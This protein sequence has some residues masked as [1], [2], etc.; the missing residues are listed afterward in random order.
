MSY[1]LSDIILKVL[2][3]LKTSSDG[4]SRPGSASNL[5]K[6]GYP[7]QTQEIEFLRSRLFSKESKH[8]RLASVGLLMLSS[9]DFGPQNHKMTE[10]VG[11]HFW[12]SLTK[13]L[14]TEDL[15]SVVHTILAGAKVARQRSEYQETKNSIKR[16]DSGSSST[17]DLSQSKRSQGARE[18]SGHSQEDQNDVNKAQDLL[19]VGKFKIYYCKKNKIFGTKKSQNGQYLSASEQARQVDV[20]ANRTKHLTLQDLEERFQKGGFLPD[21]VKYVLWVDHASGSPESIK[22]G[23]G[24]AKEGFSKSFK[25]QKGSRK[26]QA[27]FEDRMFQRGLKGHEEENL[28]LC[29]SQ[30]PFKKLRSHVNEHRTQKSIISSK[31][32]WKSFKIRKRKN[33]IKEV[34]GAPRGPFNHLG[35]QTEAFKRDI[36]GKSRKR[37]LNSEDSVGSKRSII[38][39]SGGE[40]GVK[41][42]LGRSI[43]DE[44]TSN[45]GGIQKSGKRRFRTRGSLSRKLRGQ[46]GSIMRASR[47]NQHETTIGNHQ[48]DQKSQKSNNPKFTTKTS[49]EYNMNPTTITKE[50][51]QSTGR[52]LHPESKKS[53]LESIQKYQGVQR[54]TSHHLGVRGLRARSQQANNRN[55]VKSENQ[56]VEENQDFRKKRTRNFVVK[57]RASS[58]GKPPKSRPVSR[59]A[60]EKTP[61]LPEKSKN[62]LIFSSGSSLAQEGATPSIVVRRPKKGRPKLRRAPTGVRLT[63]DQPGGSKNQDFLVFNK[64][65]RNDINK[66]KEDNGGHNQLKSGFIFRKKQTRHTENKI[67]TAKRAAN[68]AQGRGIQISPEKVKET[69]KN[70][71]RLRGVGADQLAPK[72]RQNWEMGTNVSSF[73]GRKKIT[74]E[75]YLKASLLA[76]IK[77]SNEQVDSAQK[78]VNGERDRAKEDG[79]RVESRRSLFIQMSMKA[80]KKDYLED[81]NFKN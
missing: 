26:V 78:R 11:E 1:Q 61:K 18:G 24:Q 12:L 37:T 43:K 20:W 21:P 46:R 55:G 13:E 36:F 32:R 60:V 47:E 29:A 66:E 54:T 76:C 40:R 3:S 77:R 52:G 15:Q 64:L 35:G 70:L 59:K 79:E 65:D 67:R 41:D 14:L 68:T 69:R 17:S 62:R 39:H 10:K 45:L 49:L 48:N 22:E 7:V 44:K 71:F 23:T 75:D 58:S 38:E 27:S 9:N 25:G 56:I 73:L 34:S 81:S 33:S 31:K 16:Q 42:R 72:N 5:F 50:D 74:N 4:Q 8:R 51:K 30:M 28:G 80:R 6:N 53:T 63:K 57:S 19:K 2:D